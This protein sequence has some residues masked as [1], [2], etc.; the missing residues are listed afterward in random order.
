M[1]NSGTP[2]ADGGVLGT[3]KSAKK[4]S[5]KKTGEKKAGEKKSADGKKSRKSGTKGVNGQKASKKDGKLVGS[6]KPKM[7][8]MT[9]LQLAKSPSAGANAGSPKK[10]AR[11]VGSAGGATPKLA[12]PLPPVA[13][14]LVRY[15]NSN[16]DREDRKNAISS[17]VSKAAKLLSAEE[18]GR[19][20][21]EEL[22]QLVQKRWELLEQKRRW[23][24]MTDEEKQAELQRRRVELKEKMRERAKERREKEMQARREQLR[25]FEDQELNGQPL[26]VFRPVETPEGLPNELFGDVAMVADFLSCYSGLLMPDEQYPVTASALLE[27]LGGERGGF[28]YLNR[29]LVVLLQTLLQDE[30]AEGYSELDMPISEI[31]LTMHSVSELVRL[32]LR[33]SDQDQDSARGS[34][35]NDGRGGEGA[36]LDGF[37]EVVT[38]DLLEQL[39]TREVFE[40][41]P[42]EK[43]RL[44]VALCHRILMTYS[45]VDHVDAM[46]QRSAELWK[47]R[48]ATLKE[49]NDRKRA[50]KQKRKEQMEARGQG[51]GQGQGTPVPGAAGWVKMEGGA[52]AAG[53]GVGGD[54]PQVREKPAEKEKEKKKDGGAKKDGGKVKVEVKAEP[55]PEPEPVDMISTVKSRRL[56]S[57]QAKKEKEEQERQNK[58][59]QKRVE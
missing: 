49:V 17:L 33:L 26:P 7:K 34:E 57:I 19:L 20:Q 58:G 30:L 18:R 55:L 31:P 54:S 8:Q 29:V 9:L 21:P 45:V 52:A 4:A 47:E 35:E 22:R 59:E 56:L 12:K 42:P 6:K 10:R 27:A 38:A 44:L 14:H 41:P 48:L 2:K 15:Y 24:A 28:L 32:C 23:A 3:P 46:Q 25:R 40:L 39:E 43:L 5:E 13:L 53:G 50:E 11:S 37:D 36:G 16:K 1:K 51:Q